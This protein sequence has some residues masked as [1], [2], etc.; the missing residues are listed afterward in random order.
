MFMDNKSLQYIFK[1]KELKLSKGDGLNYLKTRASTF[2]IIR[3]RLILEMILLNENPWVVW[4]PEGAP[5]YDGQGN[6]PIG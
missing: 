3:K 1:K 4:P 5:K 2:S 6:S